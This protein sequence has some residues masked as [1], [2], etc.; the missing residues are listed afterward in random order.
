MTCDKIR[1]ANIETP[2]PEIVCAMQQF[3]MSVKIRQTHCKFTQ[4]YIQLK[5]NHTEG[6]WFAR[7]D[8]QD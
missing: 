8:L 7:L 2:D 1:K 4:Q 6:A 5:K 3:Y